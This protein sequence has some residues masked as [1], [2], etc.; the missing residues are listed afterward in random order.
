MSKNCIVLLVLTRGYFS[1]SRELLSSSQFSLFLSLSKVKDGK[2][3]AF[4]M[5][6]KKMKWTA[7]IKMNPACPEPPPPTMP[8]ETGSGPSLSPISSELP[9]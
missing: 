8:S 9:T 2:D 5:R 3:G 4:Q 1:R 7:K 6:L